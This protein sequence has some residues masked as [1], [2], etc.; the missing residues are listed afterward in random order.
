MDR[1]RLRPGTSIY[2]RMKLGA[3]DLSVSSPPQDLVTRKE[4]SVMDIAWSIPHQ[5]SLV[6]I[7]TWVG[8]S[9]VIHWI[10]D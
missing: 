2:Y 4:Q 8:W 3:G 5:A 9:I 10:G 7:L 1:T 6:T